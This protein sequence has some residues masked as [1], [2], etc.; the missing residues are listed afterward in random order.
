MG[1]ELFPTGVALGRTIYLGHGTRAVPSG[2]ILVFDDGN[3]MKAAGFVPYCQDPL[4]RP[5]LEDSTALSKHTRAAGIALAATCGVTAASNFMKS[6]NARDFNRSLGSSFRVELSKNSPAI[7]FDLVLY[8][9]NLPKPA[10]VTR[11]LNLDK[12]GVD[13]V[14]AV[15]LDKVRR[16]IQ[17]PDKAVAFRRGGE[18]GFD[19]VAIPLAEQTVLKI[20]EAAQHFGW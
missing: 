14:L 8:Y 1:R 17:I 3:Q 9:V 7:V 19:V 2:D 15:F 4:N 5:P 16:Q 18:L 10:G 20:S 13:D 12:P 11:V 6:T